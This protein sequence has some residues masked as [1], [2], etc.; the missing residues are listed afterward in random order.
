VEKYDPH[1]RHEHAQDGQR[2]NDVGEHVSHDLQ[3]DG[4]HHEPH[5]GLLPGWFAL[6]HR[7]LRSPRHQADMLG[8]LGVHLCF[9]VLRDSLHP[10]RGVQ[11]FPVRR[12]SIFFAYRRL[13]L[14]ADVPTDGKADECQ[15]TY[16]RKDRLDRTHD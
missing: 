11:S 15:Q 10:N 7:L 9:E 3:A 8:G 2:E 5:Q 12:C 4:S 16:Y 6:V 14:P 13:S 1:D